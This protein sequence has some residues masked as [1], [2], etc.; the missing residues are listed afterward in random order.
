MITKVNVL[1][2]L[3][4]EYYDINAYAHELNVNYSQDK[5]ILILSTWNN[6]DSENKLFP[7]TIV[8]K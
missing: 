6:K 1:K 3:K 2:L 4:K 8:V 5:N 7:D